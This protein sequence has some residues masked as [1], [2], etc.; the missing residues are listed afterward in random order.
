MYLVHDYGIGSL[1]SVYS[2]E[3]ESTQIIFA[4]R[5]IL[6]FNKTHGK[7]GKQRYQHEDF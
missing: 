5:F 6:L 1:R 7:N 4:A 2:E 3:E